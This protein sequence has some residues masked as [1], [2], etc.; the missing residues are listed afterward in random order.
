MDAITQ[1]FEMTVERLDVSLRQVV[2]PALGL[3]LLDIGQVA[4]QELL[5][6]QNAAKHLPRNGTSFQIKLCQ[7]SP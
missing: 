3:V 1:R 2:S 5:G 6:H 4:E 7:Q